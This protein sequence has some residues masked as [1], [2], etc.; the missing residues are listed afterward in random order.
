[1]SYKP[2]SID[3]P[4]YDYLWTIAFQTNNIPVSLE[5]GGQPAVTFLKRSG[6]DTGILKQIWTLST[7]NPT[8]NINEFYTAIRYIV[9][10]QNG[11]MPLTRD[12]LIAT[13]NEKFDLPKFNDIKLPLPNVP[14]VGAGA[15]GAGPSPA[16]GSSVPGAGPLPYA[17]TADDHEKYHK[18]FITY[19]TNGDGF[20][21]GAESVGVL[22]KS[23]LSQDVLGVIW[24]LADDDKDGS[25]T[26]KEFCVAFHLI[27]CIS[28][29]G[30]PV[31]QTLPQALRAFL[32]NAPAVPVPITATPPPPAAAVPIVATSPAPIVPVTVGPVTVSV[33]EE[34]SKPVSKI[35]TIEVPESN[36]GLSEREEA[37]LMSSIVSIKETTQKAL[38]I[39]DKAIET[40]SKG[41]ESLRAL[42]QKLQGERIAINSRIEASE[43]ATKEADSKMETVVTEITELQIELSKLRKDLD[44]AKEKEFEARAKATGPKLQEKQNLLN[45]I[46]ET[47]RQFDL[48]KNENVRNSESITALS[49]EK[50]EISSKLQPLVAEESKLTDEINQLKADVNAL[51]LELSKLNK[52]N[53]SKRAKVANG[54]QDLR[55]L[56]ETLLQKEQS[57]GSLRE[58]KDDILEEKETLTQ[59]VEDAKASDE[60]APVSSGF[61]SFG[62]TDDSFK[63]EKFDTFDP[64]TDD[65]FGAPI[66]SDADP[67]GEP[68]TTSAGFESPST[69][70]SF[71]SPTLA[72]SV[73]DDPFGAPITSD[74]AADPFGAPVSFKPV[75][76]AVASTGFDDGF[77][78]FP[79]STADP[80]SD[81]AIS[82]DVDSFNAFGDT[83]NAFGDTGDAFASF[84]SK[85]AF[86]AFGEESSSSSS[87]TTTT[88]APAE[89]E[90]SW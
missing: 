52:D 87:T 1:M 65:P 70:T 53:E 14:V 39:T 73:N 42:M 57:I 28:K 8:M 49:N 64:A 60:F 5:L 50:A 46:E 81:S 3:R 51:T 69:S 6:V 86:P 80:F 7:P 44:E 56:Q 45:Q 74:V 84:D 79:S 85:S 58:Q 48:V 18:L 88:T 12:R 90:A 10:F 71:E 25:L 21:S 19:D 67:F 26:S 54:Q 72:T 89:F 33:P 13:S 17:I 22:T 35:T 15:A 32:Q 37:D 55:K 47:R 76:S 34:K 36:N 30:M 11:E 61:E 24:N 23:G 77:T 66:T 75:E 43:Q 9:M 82:K 41:M 68:I 59:K 38:T 27:I 40:S 4:I 2:T 29:K 16:A 78:A 20:L 63:A 31:P 83:T 62:D